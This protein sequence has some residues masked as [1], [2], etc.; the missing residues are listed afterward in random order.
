MILPTAYI[1]SAIF[2]DRMPKRL[3]KAKAIIVGISCCAASLLL[4]GP[5][6][7]IHTG[8][9]T[10]KVMI[11]G[12]ILLGLFIPFGLVLS[13]PTMVEHVSKKF[14]NQTGRVNNLSAGVFNTANG[15]GE[16]VGPLFGAHMYE[17]V[18]FRAT[19]DMTAVVAL[20]YVVT[21]IYILARC[22]DDKVRHVEAECDGEGDELTEQLKGNKRH[23]AV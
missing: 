15:L 1:P 9:Y 13:L 18:G 11:L 3:S 2:L 6:I 14:P 4:V 7:F 23:P 20:V 8:E 16:V 17:K 12:Q 5:S 19:S 10:M 22:P 21:F